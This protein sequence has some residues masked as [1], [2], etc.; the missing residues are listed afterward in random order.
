MHIGIRTT[1]IRLLLAAILTTLIIL[2]SLGACSPLPSH[3]SSSP[4]PSDRTEKITFPKSYV[5]SSLNNDEKRTP[6]AVAKTFKD[7]G[8]KYYTD[9]YANEDGSV[10]VVVTDKQRRN[11]I[12]AN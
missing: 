4:T 3:S 6:E 12:K 1:R 9:A 11:N 5:S 8:K 2:L 7:Q 10:T